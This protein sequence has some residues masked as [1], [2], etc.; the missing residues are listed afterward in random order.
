MSSSILGRQ[1]DFQLTLE[2]WP[3]SNPSYPGTHL[4]TD[5]GRAVQW[6]ALLVSVAG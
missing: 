6:R 2:G 5:K 3:L 4:G 1:N